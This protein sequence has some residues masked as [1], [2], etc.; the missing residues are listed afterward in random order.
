MVSMRRSLSTLSVFS[1]VVGGV[2]LGCG[3]S[4]DSNG[5]NNCFQN[6]D[7]GGTTFDVGGG[8]GSG[9]GGVGLQGISLGPVDLPVY[10]EPPTPPPPCAAT[11]V[12]PE[13]NPTG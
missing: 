5:D 8:D 9:D 10:P 6:C 7:D 2:A 3:A 12:P 4:K 13:A 1:L 11:A